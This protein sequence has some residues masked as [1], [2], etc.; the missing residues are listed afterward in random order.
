MA[1]HLTAKGRALKAELIPL[2]REVVDTAVQSLS[3][4]EIKQLLEGL[5]EVQKTFT[6]PHRNSTRSAQ[7]WS[8][9][10][11]RTP[12]GLNSDI[13]RCS[14]RAGIGHQVNLAMLASGPKRV[15]IGCSIE[16]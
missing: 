12:D 3:R 11:P 6:P 2:A 13:A 16:D 10:G 7:G 9:R 4:K 5:A 1:V 14:L 8:N 15:S